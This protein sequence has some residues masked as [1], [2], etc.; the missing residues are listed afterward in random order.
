MTSVSDS[1]EQ[2][3]AA[4]RKTILADDPTPAR[5]QWRFGL[6]E[7]GLTLA[8][9]LEARFGPL[10]GKRVLDVG[11]AFGGD[12]VAL[13]ARGAD[14]VLTDIA[15]HGY[16]RLCETIGGGSR[17]S[18]LLCDCGRTW[19][20]ADGSFDL[21]VCIGVIEH[22]RDLDTFFA[23]VARV[24]KPEGVALIDTPPA[25]RM[26]R[27]DSH[28]QL[29]L[30]SLLPTRWRCWV[31]E[32]VFGRRYELQL[33]GRTFY[34]A[35][36]LRHYVARRGYRVL[37]VKYR[38]STIMARVARWPFASFWRSLIRRFVYDFMLIV[39]RTAT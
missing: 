17:L 25:L 35:G 6:F 24:L 5:R 1:I 10:A 2:V 7:R 39:P 31:A 19:P 15:D 36:Q 9:E 21:V 27:R 37:P 34:S 32:H 29:P 16:P 30:V 20:L 8:D 33:S 11:A 3:R 4:Y 18:C 28:Y 38:S 12:A 23:E 14:C 13:H 22:V 26:A